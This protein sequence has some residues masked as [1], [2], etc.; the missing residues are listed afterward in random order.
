MHEANLIDKLNYL[1][2]LGKLAYTEKDISQRVQRTCDSIEKD[3][4]IGER[5]VGG[6]GQED[7]R[8]IILHTR[9][10]MSAGDF[11]RLRNNISEYLRY[12][13]FQRTEVL[14]RR[15]ADGL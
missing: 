5:A 9:D 13:G 12:L 11:A 4:G 1:S 7:G 10:G 15:E 6:V 3:L 2:K 8:I 14:T